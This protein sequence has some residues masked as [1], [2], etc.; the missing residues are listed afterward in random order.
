MQNMP[1]ISK[2][3]NSRA[4]QMGLTGGGQFGQNGQKLH[5]NDKIDMCC[6]VWGSPPLGEIL[7]SKITSTQCNQLT[8]C[9]CQVNEECL[10]NSK[11]QLMDIV[12]SLHQ[13]REKST[14]GWQK[15]NGRK[16]VIIKK[17]I[18]PQYSHETVLSSYV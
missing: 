4:S 11:C 18:Q 6:V 15:E 2:G 9:N 14:F 16:G 1:K 7:N 17:V 10:M 13:N 3:H 5:E 12:M 8:F